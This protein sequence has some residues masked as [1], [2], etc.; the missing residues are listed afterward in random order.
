[1]NATYYR[2]TLG[3]SEPGNRRKFHLTA[4]ADETGLRITACNYPP[5]T[6]SAHR[7]PHVQ[8]HDR[9]GQSLTSYRTIVELIG[10]ITKTKGLR[11]KAERNTEWCPIGVKISDA[12]M[13]A[14]YPQTALQP[15]VRASRRTR[16][17]KNGATLA[18]VRASA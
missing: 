2:H 5:G 15:S 11:I 6:L 1:M 13:A 18:I 3:L 16:E 10:V 8:L 7:A 14:P 9:R 17:A 4:I 12:E